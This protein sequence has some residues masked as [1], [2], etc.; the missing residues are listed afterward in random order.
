MKWGEFSPEPEEGEDEDKTNSVD[1]NPTTT[2][3]P[4]GGGEEND[5]IFLYWTDEFDWCD[6]LKFLW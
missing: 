2:D 3:E 4:G 6:I 5:D 1:A